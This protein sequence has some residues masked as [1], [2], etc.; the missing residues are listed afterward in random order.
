MSVRAWIPDDLWRGAKSWTWCWL[1]RSFPI[2]RQ[3]H[4]G[5]YPTV[6]RNDR[7]DHVGNLVKIF[8]NNMISTLLAD[9]KCGRGCVLASSTNKWRKKFTSRC[10]T[11]CR[12]SNITSGLLSYGYYM[13]IYATTLFSRLITY[14]TALTWSNGQHVF[15]LPAITSASITFILEIDTWPKQ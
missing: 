5:V 13:I 4:L 15:A 9:G 3:V 12:F 14:S 2:F 7:H 6:R 11:I 10:R 1:E 8:V